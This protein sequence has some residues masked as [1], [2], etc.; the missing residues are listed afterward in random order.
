MT[1]SAAMQPCRVCGTLKN[2]VR[3]SARFCM[4]ACGGGQGGGVDETQRSVFVWTVF[5]LWF[6]T[7]C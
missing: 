7:R 3:K 4:K 2:E 6:K 5:E 1:H